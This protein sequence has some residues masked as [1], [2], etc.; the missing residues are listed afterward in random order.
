MQGAPGG[1]ATGPRRPLQASP[2]G[3][4]RG[5]QAPL[6]RSVPSQAC[7]ART[8]ERAGVPEPCRDEGPL[9][10]HDTERRRRQTHVGVRSTREAGQER[11]RDSALVAPS[12]SVWGPGRCTRHLKTRGRDG[13][14]GAAVG[15]GRAETNDSAVEEA[16][17]GRRDRRRSRRC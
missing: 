10:P 5:R 12:P 3:G 13:T 4:A 11:P 14:A 15:A 17:S 16:A 6:R 2:G 1:V 8:A 9:G 7:A